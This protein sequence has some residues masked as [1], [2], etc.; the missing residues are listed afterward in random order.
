MNTKVGLIILAA[1][2][3]K[4]I[5][6]GSINKVALPMQG[7]PMI[8][9]IVERAL[10][11]GVSSIV[12]V[13][14]FAKESVKAV[15]CDYDVVF[16]EQKERLGTAHALT[17]GFEGMDTTVQQI[18]VLNGDDAFFLSAE[19]LKNFIEVHT[20]SDV[21]FSM[22]TMELDNPFGIGRVV[23]NDAGNIIRVVEEKDATDEEKK[24]QEVNGIGY[25]FTRKF[26][27]TYLPRVEKSQKTGEYYLTSL[28]EL[29]AKN[30]EKIGSLPL[31]K[32]PWRGVNTLQDL[33]TAEQLFKNS[34]N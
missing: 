19:V 23:R 10:E 28:I 26:L 25:I 8:V 32:I 16:R 22:L 5:Q 12:V 24:I 11:L 20:T 3:G 6:A 18:L 15:L 17:T 4:R 34:S 9:R 21:S 33:E 1:G 13:V 31:G 30:N 27:E 7:K 29:A 14:G 2:E